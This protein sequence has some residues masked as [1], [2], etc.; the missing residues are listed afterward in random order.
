MSVDM[1][2]V[3]CLF[4]NSLLF[5]KLV[6]WKNSY[7]YHAVYLWKLGLMVIVLSHASHMY[8]WQIFKLFPFHARKLNIWFCFF[9]NF[10]WLFSLWFL[11]SLSFFSSSFVEDIMLEG[12]Y[13]LIFGSLAYFRL[14]I[15]IVGT[16]LA[17]WKS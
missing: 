8:S 13:L 2:S 9:S 7:Y 4:T 16:C 3:L 11:C 1:L 12:L 15:C 10:L 6:T 5:W 14:L 17:S